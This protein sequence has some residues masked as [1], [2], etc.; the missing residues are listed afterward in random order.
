MNEPKLDKYYRGRSVMDWYDD[1]DRVA[2]VKE[3]DF[4]CGEDGFDPD[5]CERC[6][7]KDICSQYGDYLREKA[8]IDRFDYVD[9]I[10]KEGEDAFLSSD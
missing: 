6:A 4:G 8:G 7:A 5:Y 9:K 10:L 1:D 3:L 2:I